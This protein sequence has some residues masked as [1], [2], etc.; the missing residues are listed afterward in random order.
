MTFKQELIG[1]KEAFYRK[2]FYVD[3]PKTK[4]KEFTETE[5]AKSRFDIYILKHGFEEALDLTLNDIVKHFKIRSKDV[6]QKKIEKR[7][8]RRNDKLKAVKNSKLIQALDYYL[9]SRIGHLSMLF[10]ENKDL[11]EEVF[12]KFKGR[13]N[14]LVIEQRIDKIILENKRKSIDTSSSTLLNIFQTKIL[15][16]QNISNP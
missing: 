13:I 9:Q 6:L 4:A 16:K 14:R 8:D 3:D 11:I 15:P 5:Y 7:V 1:K 2:H 12:V 10:E